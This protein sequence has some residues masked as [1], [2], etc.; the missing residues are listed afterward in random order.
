MAVGAHEAQLRAM[1]EA[2]VG[3]R[4][5]AGR[6]VPQV[7][8]VVR[9]SGRTPTAY[10]PEAT[11]TASGDIVTAS[12]DIVTAGGYSDLDFKAAFDALGVGQDAF[13]V[14]MGVSVATIRQAR[15]RADSPAHRS[16]PAR[17]QQAVQ[18]IAEE[19]AA[20]Y[21]RLADQMRAQLEP[22]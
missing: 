11:V 5:Q 2:R 21:L 13:A 14:A 16:P 4:V 18:V 15:V 9:G 8:G 10:K 1:R 22:R 6:V 20:H 19:R 17:W 3:G 12:S 7:D